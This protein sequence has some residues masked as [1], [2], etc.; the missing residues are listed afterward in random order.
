[1]SASTA[2]YTVGHSVHSADVFLAL[3]QQHAIEAICDVRSMPHSRRQ[4]HFNRERLT[5]A[6]AVQGIRYHFLGLEL[7]ARRS[8][9]ECY[10]DG[11]AD[12]GRIAE[13]PAFRHGL[14]QV[15]ELAG[16]ARVAL[17]CAE[18]EP[19]DCHRT[20]LVCRYLR[21]DLAI[22]HILADGSLENHTDTE[23][24]LMRKMRISRGLFD[25]SDSLNEAYDKRGL[26]IAYA[27]I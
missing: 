16:E 20:I 23:A 21:E 1:M 3:L 11:R 14:D 13:L 5:D 18:K 19:L 15:R 7:G 8:E 12:Y 10:I 24:R 9:E 27:R 6:L 22:A 17:M 2:L 25:S 4:P 26:Q